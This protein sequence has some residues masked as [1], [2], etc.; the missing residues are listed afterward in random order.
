MEFT[1]CKKI[2]LTKS[3]LRSP[4]GTLLYSKGSDMRNGCPLRAEAKSPNHKIKVIPTFLL[5]LSNEPLMSCRSHARHRGCRIKNPAR[6]SGRPALLTVRASAR[7]R[8][9]GAE[10]RCGKRRDRRCPKRC[11][12]VKTFH[13]LFSPTGEGP[14]VH[15]ESF[16]LE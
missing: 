6:D 12:A 16:L 5:L 10:Y 8:R 13:H 3:A 11:E 14:G 2:I 4:T 1:T 7:H 9:D 15:L